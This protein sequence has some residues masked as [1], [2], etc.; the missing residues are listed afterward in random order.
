M[1]ETFLCVQAV[2]LH[3]DK[4]KAGA[5]YAFLIVWQEKEGRAGTPSDWGVEWRAACRPASTVQSLLN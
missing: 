2:C 4:D 5:P 1:R 3:L